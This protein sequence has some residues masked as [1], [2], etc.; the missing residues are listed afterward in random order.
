MKPSKK[1]I[2]ELAA[3][4]RANRAAVAAARIHPRL[5]RGKKVPPMALVPPRPSDGKKTRFH[6]HLAHKAALAGE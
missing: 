1:K 5:R 6:W 3:Q 4:V 2:E